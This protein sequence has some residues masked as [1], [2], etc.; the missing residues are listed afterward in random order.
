MPGGG[1][2]SPTIRL[3]MCGT[4]NDGRLWHVSRPRDDSGPVA[5]W[6][7][8][9]SWEE[10]K[11]MGADDAGP[12]VNVACAVDWRDIN[13]QMTEEFHVCAL[14]VDG[15]LLHTSRISPDDWQPFEDLKTRI[16]GNWDTFQV[17]KVA[18]SRSFDD[19]F[20]IVLTTQG[21]HRILHVTH[22][23]DG[24]QGL[25]DVTG[26]N[27]AGFPGSFTNSACAKVSP[28]PLIV[29]LH[30]CGVTQDGKLWHTML[31]WLEDS[32]QPFA[33]VQTL[34]KSPPHGIA[35]ISIAQGDHD[36]H[37]FAQAAGD[38]WHTV[39]LANPPNWQSHFDRVKE[40]AGDPGSFGSIS[41]ADVDGSL[42]LCGATQDG[43]LWH[44]I[45]TSAN[46]LQWQRFED[47]TTAGGGN[48]GFF[49]C[50]NIAV[51]FFPPSF[52]GAD[53]TCEQIK[54]NIANDRLQ[55]RMLQQRNRNDPGIAAR[56]QD[57]ARLQDRG[58]RHHPPCSPQDIA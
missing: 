33:D 14:T 21:Q 49:T 3:H 35:D 7:P 25:E 9:S 13:S 38:L 12:F 57:I 24:T 6:G 50:V 32:W 19:V 45:R 41:A 20:I 34:A 55:I 56:N 58:R 4:T 43:K 44:T 17:E 27:E 2:P 39:R 8:W 26:A 51:N 11:A 54:R 40:Q 5:S 15:R 36:L 16:Q 18:L 22:N 42:H 53:T 48:P 37:V 10:V 28:E 30:L 31:E 47:V 46:P 1:Q 23:P 52:S 29:E